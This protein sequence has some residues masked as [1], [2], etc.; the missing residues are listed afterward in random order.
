MIREPGRH[1]SRSLQTL[2]DV[3]RAVNGSGQLMSLLQPIIRR[4]SSNRRRR[5]VGL[6]ICAAASERR[7]R[8]RRRLQRGEAPT[9]A[10][11]W[12]FGW[13]RQ[14]VG[15]G[16]AAAHD[17]TGVQSMLWR[18]IGRANSRHILRLGPRRS[19]E[20]IP[21]WAYGPR[22]VS[23]S[24]TVRLACRALQRKAA[25]TVADDQGARETEDVSKLGSIDAWV[26]QAIEPTPT[27]KI[28]S[29]SNVRRSA[30]L[31]SSRRGGVATALPPVL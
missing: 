7:L 25:R 17:L 23:R 8:F 1:S 29:P 2:W 19:A 28:R 21:W 20:G 12:D 27:V 18:W 3:Y 6:R 9:S 11:D 31:A 13:Y 24:W 30:H 10:A 14:T 22:L 26:S 5:A 16:P 15:L 4:V